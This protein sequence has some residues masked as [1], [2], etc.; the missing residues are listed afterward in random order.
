MA[1]QCE[2]PQQAPSINQDKPHGLSALLQSRQCNDS[3]SL[4]RMDINPQ[5]YLNSVVGAT[6]ASR[7][8]KKVVDYLPRLQDTS[9]SEFDLGAGVSLQLGSGVKRKLESTT[10]AQW[11]V[12]NSR[13][14]AEL[15]AEIPMFNIQDYLAYTVKIGELA[16][17]FTWASVLSYDDEYRR[18][19][20]EL[21][22]RWGSDSQH[23][24]TITL[25]ERDVST[26]S[27]G[28]S[29]L[30][31]QKEGKY[32]GY[33]NSGKECPFKDECKYAHVCATCGKNHRK[34]DHKDDTS[35]RTAVKSE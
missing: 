8:Y 20:S 12:A 14:M 5:V 29:K 35:G 6:R 26:K 31:Q 32:C 10:P 25:R 21:K 19:Q 7:S 34:I 15:I 4:P 13:I 30:K 22:Y 24:S 9:E 18:R 2:I 17:R 28:K 3:S 33:Y 16:Q 23:L 27:G 1:N 11:I